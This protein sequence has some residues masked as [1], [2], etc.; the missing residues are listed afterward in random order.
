MS[1]S[2]NQRPFEILKVIK[3]TA[4]AAL[5]GAG[6]QGARVSM[7]NYR[8]CSVLMPI[9]NATTVTGTAVTLKQHDAASSGNTKALAFTQMWS[10]IDVGANADNLA[11][12]TVA[13]NTFTTD[14]TNSKELLY[15]IEVDSESLDWANGFGWFSAWGQSAVASTGIILYVLSEPRYSG[16]GI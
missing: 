11:V 13:S 10:N 4:L 8:K 15:V 6:G 1:L 5:T 3:A 2:P 12:Q 16:A 7:K 14:A 9:S